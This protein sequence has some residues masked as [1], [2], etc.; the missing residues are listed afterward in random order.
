[1]PYD[2]AISEHGDLILA[3]NRDYAGV[4]GQALI[5]QRIRLRLRITRESWV[6]DQ[7]LGSRLHTQAGSSPEEISARAEAIVR[8]ALRDMPDVTVEGVIVEIESS[9]VI[10]VHVQ[11]TAVESVFGNASDVTSQGTLSVTVPLGG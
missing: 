2:I 11:Y 3:A 6:F 10:V 1:M 8:E 9:H 7:N 4:S 5:E